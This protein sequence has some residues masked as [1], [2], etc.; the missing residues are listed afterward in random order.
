MGEEQELK[1]KK[2]KQWN[3][4]KKGF[5]QRRQTEKEMV[6][7]QNAL[8]GNRRKKKNN[9]EIRQKNVEDKQE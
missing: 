7:K 3:K 2:D 6:S 5:K 9:K 8:G 1:S 4:T